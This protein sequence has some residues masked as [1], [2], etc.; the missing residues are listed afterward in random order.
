ML[1]NNADTFMTTPMQTTVVKGGNTAY[2]GY[3]TMPN[4]RSGGSATKV[5]TMAG[6]GADSGVTADPSDVVAQ[7][8]NAA[9]QFIPSQKQ[10]I[11]AAASYAYP[12]PAKKSNTLLYVGLAVAALAGGFL[13]M[14]KRA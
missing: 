11:Q 9:Q 1:G 2:G 10:N 13:L 7:L 12:A 6:I 3:N 8:A 14:R 5:V 4:P